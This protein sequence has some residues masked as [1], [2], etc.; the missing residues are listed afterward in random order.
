MKRATERHEESRTSAELARTA[1]YGPPPINPF[2]S[3][4]ESANLTLVEFAAYTGVSKQALIRLEQGTY[5]DPL[6][7]VLDAVI[8]D[9]TVSYLEL[10]NVYEQFQ[11]N[12]R[13]RHHRYFG[14]IIF[15]LNDADPMIHPM[16]VIRGNYNPTEVAKALCLPQA[17]LEHFERKAKHQQSVPKVIDSVLREIGYY[18]HEVLMFEQ[19]YKVYRQRLLLGDDNA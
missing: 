19:A 9:Y 5:A 15:K 11:V 18:A 14:N 6:P 12:M 13:K 10:V 8:Q 1:S 17:T 2:K 3:L 7:T 16:R 4:R